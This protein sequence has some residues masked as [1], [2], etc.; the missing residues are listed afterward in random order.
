VKDSSGAPV[1][2]VTVVASTSERGLA[3]ATT[4]ANGEY[5]II[6]LATG[7]YSVSAAFPG[8]QSASRSALEV[9]DD[10]V[11]A[12]L[13][14]DL[15]RVSNSV[16]VTSSAIDVRF[17]SSADSTVPSRV[18]FLSGQEIERQQTHNLAQALAAIPGVNAET[19]G[20]SES[21]KVKFRGV[22]S[23][24]FMGE[25]P[26]VAI[27]IDGVPVYER[28]GRPNIDLD[29]I[30]SVRV[31]KGGASYLFGEDALAGAMLITTK[32]GPDNGDIIHGAFDRG[33]Y[34]YERGTLSTGLTE[35]WGTAFAQGTIR[36]GDDY[37]FQS[38]YE[39][40]AAT[41]GTRIITGHSSDLS[42]GFEWDDR[43][44]DKH[45]T[46]TG[47]TQSL[48]DPRA[49][50]SRDYSRKFGVGLD[51]VN[52]TY[53]KYG[54]S[55]PEDNII[56]LGYQYRDH[57][58]FWSAP[59]KFSATG[60]A[61]TSPNAYE[62][63]NN[64]H[65]TQRKIKTEGRVARGQFALLGGAEY[66]RNEFLNLVTAIASYRNSPYSASVSEGT[67][68]ENNPTLEQT[69]A[70]Y[71]EAKW[72]PLT[73]LTATANERIDRLGINYTG[74]PS[75]GNAYE[76]VKR[77]KP[78]LVESYRAGATYRAVS[79][80]ELYGNVSSGFRA[81]SA[82]QLYSGDQTLT[83]N[84]RNNADLKSEQALNIEGGA[85][86]RWSLA[87]RPAT[88]DATGFTIHRRD[89]IL[90]TGGDYSPN[91][92]NAIEQYA[93]IGGARHTGAEVAFHAQPLGFL[94]ADIA[95]TYLDAHFTRYDTFYL[96]LGNQYGTYVASQSLL[97]KPSS[98]FTII[99]YNNTGN[100]LPATP[101]HLLNARLSTRTWRKVTGQAEVD[102]HAT[103]FADEI[104]QQTWPGWTVTNLRLNYD[105]P[106]ERFAGLFSHARLGFYA[107]ADNVFNKRYWEFARGIGDQQSYAT[108]FAYDGKYN[109]EDVS[110]VV[111]P[112][113]LLTAGLTLR[114]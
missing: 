39:T 113:R 98:Q 65:Q 86:L 21:V 15:A 103:S 82:S 68:A 61:V 78:F 83:G 99:T 79:S 112:G 49:T 5:K 81:P 58:T 84:V 87:K 109:A 35:K 2:G 108:N 44:R 13:T 75:S 43:D 105:V 45:G 110:I 55:H 104:N 3:R 111:A 101:P 80:L 48:L 36:Q 4:D 67:V 66:K 38:G 96:V 27:I 34:G 74:L 6:D 54:I 19:Q 76:P 40:V 77:F 18:T 114:F 17:D 106:S 69:W 22:D 73:R 12:D 24:V 56:V 62:D 89:M 50:L 10:A 97:T 64:Y 71:G 107:R 7:T 46:V 52:L 29:D 63:E 37:Y 92:P 8:F 41:A 23:Q 26:G 85:R 47:I 70:G 33:S 32:R 1:L 20:S 94:K 91:N 42:L 90:E 11:R 30:D 57:T 59:L 95:Y 102:H 31:V 72:S 25:K 16:T 100:K 53:S 51:R 28:T 60:A 88:V 14:I 9:N 93:N